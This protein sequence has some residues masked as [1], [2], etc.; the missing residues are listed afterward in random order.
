MS[1]FMNYIH[2]SPFQ[3]LVTNHAFLMWMFFTPL[4]R[5]II[6]SV[7][8][9]NKWKRNNLKMPSFWQYLTV[10]IRLTERKTKCNYHFSSIVKNDRK[11]GLKPSKVRRGKW[12]AQIF[13]KDL[14]ERKLERTWMKIMLSASLSLFFFTQ[15]SQYQIFKANTYSILTNTNRTWTASVVVL[16]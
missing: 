12:L 10:Q 4:W 7:K 5:T 11:D 13:R 2:S 9:T 8:K 16:N 1:K 6:S 3:Y 15:S 14:T